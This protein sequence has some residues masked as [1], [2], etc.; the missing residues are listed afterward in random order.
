MDFY[1]ALQR[2][3]LSLVKTG[4]GSLGIARV[5][6]K[7]EG[8]DLPCLCESLSSIPGTTIKKK[9]LKGKEVPGQMVLSSMEKV[10]IIC[11]QWV[12]ES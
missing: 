7:Q 6:A 2:R 1:T 11:L 10:I 9:T 12:A 3:K 5:G 8:R 4:I